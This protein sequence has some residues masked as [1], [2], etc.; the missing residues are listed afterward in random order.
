M[1]AADSV[2]DFRSNIATLMT[3]PPGDR[4]QRCLPDDVIF[5]G[6]MLHP[7]AESHDLEFKGLLPEGSLLEWIDE[8]FGGPRSID[9]RTFGKWTNVEM[10]MAFLP[11]QARDRMYFRVF[12]AQTNLR[13]GDAEE[14]KVYRAECTLAPDT[15]D[16]AP[17]VRCHP[18]KHGEF[19]SYSFWRNSFV[20]DPAETGR[21]CE[22]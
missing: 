3:C 22:P 12:P 4:T 8:M 19:T 10:G 7:L 2:R 13:D 17:P 9:D 1:A 18:I 15:P 21:T 5:H 6:L 20:C 14:Q 11:A 16:A